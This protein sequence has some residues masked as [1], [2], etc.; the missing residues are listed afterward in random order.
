M[1]GLLID[2]K[3][4]MSSIRFRASIKIPAYTLQRGES[5]IIDAIRRERSSASKENT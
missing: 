1:T 5:R 4:E 2:K 3:S